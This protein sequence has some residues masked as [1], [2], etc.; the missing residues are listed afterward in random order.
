MSEGKAAAQAGHAWTDVLLHGLFSDIPAVRALAQAY[1][2]LKPGTKVCLDG[3]D[4]T[5]LLRL[6]D[7]LAADGIPHVLIHDQGH[8]E[9]PH[10]DGGRILTAVG[11]GPLTRDMRPRALRRLRLWTGGARLRALA[12]PEPLKT[13]S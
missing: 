4:G 11:V 13:S 8:V 2:A 9:P 1:A 5:D 12:V 10:F 6:A 7:S 3:G